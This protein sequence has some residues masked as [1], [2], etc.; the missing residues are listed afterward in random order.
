MKYFWWFQ[1]QMESDLVVTGGWN[2]T[3]LLQ[4]KSDENKEIVLIN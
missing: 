4:K 3:K 2:S 1:N